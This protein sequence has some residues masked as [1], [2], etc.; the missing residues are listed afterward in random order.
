MTDG[1]YSNLEEDQDLRSKPL[2]CHT[3]MLH[4]EETIEGLQQ[5]GHAD[6]AWQE[7]WRAFITTSACNFAPLIHDWITHSRFT[8]NDYEA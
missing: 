2:Y 7:R 6:S 3:T 8:H 4:K 1:L 5:F